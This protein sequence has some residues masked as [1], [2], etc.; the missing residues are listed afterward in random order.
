M[1]CNRDCFSC[2]FPDCIDTAYGDS[3]REYKKTGIVA[4]SSADYFRQYNQLRKA[5]RKAYDKQ[6]QQSHREQINEKQKAYY[7]K[8]KGEK[9]SANGA[10]LK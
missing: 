8:R 7:W 10:E 4:S 3:K 5:Y 1:K 9:C 2:Q 6:Y